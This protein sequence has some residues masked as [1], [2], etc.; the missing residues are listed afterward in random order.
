MI[1]LKSSAEIGMM[2]KSGLVLRDLLLH[3]EEKI[4]PGISTKKLDEFAYDYIKRHG[5]T[6]SFLGYGGFP[7]SIC[8]SVDEAVV[9]GIPGHKRLE[10]GMI[11]G[12]DAGVILNGWQSDAARTFPVGKGTEEKRR[13]VGVT[14]ESFFEGVKHFKEGGR[15][16]DISAA[17]QEYNESRG[18]GVVRDLVGHGIGRK[19]HEDPAVPN[20]G[21]AG[22][23]VKLQRGL[24]LAIEP[25]V[26]MGT[27]KVITLDDEWTCVTADGKPSAHYENTVA[28]TENGAEILTL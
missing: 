20:F 24:V 22:H 10:E 25:M 19:M 6:P 26:N 8:T 11:V 18:Y 16:G 9:H 3:L 4:R 15:L 2:R 1:N 23:G 27:W 28:L 13:G 21:T 17:I 5:G 12:I 14:R 7:A